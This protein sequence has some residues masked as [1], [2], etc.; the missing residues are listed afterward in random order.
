MNAP[1]P[2]QA[3]GL[4]RCVVGDTI[5]TML[6]DGYLDV[7]FD[8]LTGVDPAEA[9]QI[10]ATYNTPKLPRININCFVIQSTGRTMLIDGGAGGINGWGGRLPFALAAAG[11]DPLSIDTI[12][13]T[14]AHPDHVGGLAGPLATPLFGNV[15]RFVVHQDELAFWKNDTIRAGAPATFKPFFDLARNVFDAYDDRLVPFKGEDIQLPGIIAVPLP[16]HTPGHSGYLVSDK[17]SSLLIWGDIVHFPHIQVTRPDVTIAF[18][19]DAGLAAASRAKILDRVA[20]ER[21]TI[22]GMHFNAPAVGRIE[23]T[24]GAFRLIYEPW[25]PAAQQISPRRQ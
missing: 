3:P 8:L 1:L 12:L 16:G 9:E 15:D 25:T 22:T 20:S 19:G 2:F 13:L 21:L 4:N 14:H 24:S 5:V 17:G 11:I 10:L 18:D 7:S 23:G 6:S